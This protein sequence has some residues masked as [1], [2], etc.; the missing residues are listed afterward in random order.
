MRQKLNAT[1]NSHAGCRWALNIKDK[2]GLANNHQ[3][4]VKSILS[5]VGDING[6]QAQTSD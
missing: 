4:P 6:Y 5:N 1:Y 3:K 2:P